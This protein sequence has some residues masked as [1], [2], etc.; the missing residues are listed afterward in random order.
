MTNKLVA[1]LMVFGAAAALVSAALAQQRTPQPGAQNRP[2]VGTQRSTPEAT[3]A[4]PG[5]GGD[6]QLRQRIE[7]LEEQFV[8]LQIV[9][10]TLESLA[11]T[12]GAPPPP[13]SF[14]PGGPLGQAS[15]D[16]GRIEALETQVRALTVQLERLSEQIRTLESSPG[17]APQPAPMGALDPRTERPEL[18]PSRES[19]P[20]GFGSTTVTKGGPDPIG[21]LLGADPR[22]EAARP[23]APGGGNSKQVYETAY[24]YLLQQNYEAAESAFGDFL[25]RFPDDELAANAQYWLGE[26]YFV[27]GQYK[28]AAGAFLKGSRTYSK[29]AKG[30]DSMLKLAMSLDR[31]GQRDAACQAFSELGA[32]Y[33]NPPAYVRERAQSERQRAGCR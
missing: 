30:P 29:S 12:G 16:A 25:K 9:V 22:E 17:A 2:G 1:R 23:A 33:P 18:D 6:S 31:L 3:A 5:R 24:G 28:A 26:T 7:Q 13:G 20:G 27:R 14:G 4:D 8:D 10:G 15:Q 32:R 19:R 21:Q 11:R